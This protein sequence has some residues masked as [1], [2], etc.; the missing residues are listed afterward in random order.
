[1]E[2]VLYVLWRPDGLDA[3]EWGARLRGDVA[4]RL[5]DAGAL[6]V[7]LNVADSAVAAAMLRIEHTTPQMAAVLG[8]WLDS[9]TAQWRRA[10]DDAVAPAAARVEAYLVTES[11]TLHNTAHPPAAGER[12]DGFANLA[13]LQRPERL[14]YDEWLDAWLNEHSVIA[15]DIQ[16]T[17][18]YVQNVVARRLTPDAP[19]FDGIVEECFPI[20]ALTDFH[21]F[22]DTGGD[23]GEL[24]RRMT[25]MTDST[26]KF[27]DALDV[28][29]TSQYVVRPLRR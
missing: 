16:G 3:D 13:F 29:P 17:F 26:S 27:I 4:A 11:E 9:A 18:R 22:F 19:P 7:Q 28:V 6:A 5:L 20:E 15:S 1:M 8:V 10:F 25:Q 24:G 14:T 21:A 12:T 2:K 23:D